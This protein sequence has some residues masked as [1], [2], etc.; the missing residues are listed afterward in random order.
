MHYMQ[1]NGALAR[2]QFQYTCVQV[3]GLTTSIGVIKGTNNEMFAIGLVFSLVVSL[4]PPPIFPT[5]TSAV[6]SNPL[7]D[8]IRR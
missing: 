4:P 8:C 6:V 7:L 3:I 5:T 1:D 2:I